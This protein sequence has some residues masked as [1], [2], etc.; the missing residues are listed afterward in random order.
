[1]ASR[2][3][4]DAEERQ[5]LERI[6]ARDASAFEALHRR[7][8]DPLCGFAARMVR[9]RD[10]AEEI[11]S[12]T[13]MAVWRGAGRFE[14]R[15]KVSTWVFGIA[16]R[17]ALKA[18]RRTDPSTGAEDIDA[19]HHIA[20]SKV[21]PMEARLERDRVTALLRSLPIEQRAVMELCYYYGRSVTE[22]SDITGLPPGTIKSRMHAARKRL[23]EALT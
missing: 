21:V 20:D 17:T 5:W 10:R 22:V 19:A 7:Y 12:D 16:Y 6:A 15:S 4:T 8:F 9:E 14:G 23:K 18:L 3:T 1:M 13:L 11:A 2:E